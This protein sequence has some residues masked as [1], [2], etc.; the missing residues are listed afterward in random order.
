MAGVGSS[1]RASFRS[2]ARPINRELFSAVTELRWRMLVNSLRT[3]RGR[4]ELVS[5]ALV[6]FGVT[7]LSLGGAVFLVPMSLISRLS[8]NHPGYIAAA[9][10]FIFG[11]WQLYPVL[12]LARLPCLSSSP[13]CCASR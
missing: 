10:W 1:P 5:R 3:I 4:L 7:M 13:R 6:G 11:F 2:L 8:T 9:L 12:E